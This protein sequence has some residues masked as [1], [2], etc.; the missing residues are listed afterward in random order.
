MDE[1]GTQLAWTLVVKDEGGKVS[2]SLRGGQ[3][4][5]E[6]ELADPKV[7][8]NTLSFKIRINAQETVEVVLKTDGKKL[9]GSFKGKDSGTGSFNGTKHS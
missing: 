4:G 7:E 2:A 1:R 8:G 5:A 6:L 3:D 9:G